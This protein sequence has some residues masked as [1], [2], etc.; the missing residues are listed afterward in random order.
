MACI[1]RVPS[2]EHWTR[3]LKN[4]KIP[5]LPCNQRS[6]ALAP[7][8]CKLGRGL[9]TLHWLHTFQ[10]NVGLQGPIRSVWKWARG[11]IQWGRFITSCSIDVGG[12]PHSG[13]RRP[14]DRCCRPRI[15]R[16]R[17]RRSPAPDQELPCL[18][19]PAAEAVDRHS[20]D[21]RLVAMH[22]TRA[23]PVLRQLQHDHCVSIEC[24]VVAQ[25]QGLS[26]EAAAFQA[27]DWWQEQHR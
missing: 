15:S 9:Q 1:H 8:I 18:R 23:Y 2:Q 16:H 5:Q 12:A 3:S 21:Q 22:N 20:S 4:T 27:G 7:Q 24:H 6:A 19:G 26:H 13:L 17:T 11:K 14:Q 10:V 25:A